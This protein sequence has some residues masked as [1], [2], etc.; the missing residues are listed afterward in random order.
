MRVSIIRVKCKD[1]V[2]Y[3]AF[4]M[5]FIKKNEKLAHFCLKRQ[6]IIVHTY[7]LSKS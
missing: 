2:C 7:I 1:V 3:N 5:N 4:K 6:R